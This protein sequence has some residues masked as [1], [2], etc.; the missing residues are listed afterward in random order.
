MNILIIQTAFIG[1]VILATPIIETIRKNHPGAEIDFVLRKGNQALLEGHPYVRNIF[2]WE[3]SSK[4]KSLFKIIRQIRKNRYTYIINLQRFL[5]TGLISIL[6]RANMKV[7]FSKNPLSGFYKIKKEHEIKNGVHEVD[8]N[9]A[10]VEDFCYE[11]VRMPKLYPSQNDEEAVKFYKASKYV[12]MAPTSVWFTKQ[13]HAAGWIGLINLKSDKYKVFLL[14]GSGDY[15][16]CET[17]QKK[18]GSNNVVNLAGKLNFLESAALMR[19]AAMNY[20]NDSAPLHMASAM[21][22]PVTAIFCS[23]I[24]EYGFGPLSDNSKVLQAGKKLSCKPCG[25]HGR[26][27]CPEGHFD[28][29]KTIIID[30]S[31]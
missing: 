10:L 26:K 4:Y 27:E 20:A 14:G 28:C 9:L 15:D 7:G 22:A 13:F 30:S 23:T 31:V 21:N 16:A 1:D 3:K 8:R 29:A 11:K 12:C 25:L 19:D 2:I 17:I 24:P 18:S 6:G 5:N